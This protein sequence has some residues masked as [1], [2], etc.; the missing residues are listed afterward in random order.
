MTEPSRAFLVALNRN[1]LDATALAGAMPA[2]L[3]SAA[4]V[5]SQDQVDTLLGTKEASIAAGT[6][7][8]VWQGDKTW[9]AKTGLPISTATQTALDLKLDIASQFTVSDIATG[10]SAT[11]PAAAKLCTVQSYAVA[12]YGEGRAVYKR[13]A[14]EPSSHSLKFR[15]TDRFLPDGTTSA[16][17]GGWWEIAES[18]ITPAMAGARGDNTTTDDASLLVWAAACNALGA[19][20]V[21]EPGKIHRCT[22]TCVIALTV[23]Y[24]G[25]GAEFTVPND[26]QSNHLFGFD[27]IAA[28]I[29]VVS[30]ATLNACTGLKKGSNRIPE[31]TDGNWAYWFMSTDDVFMRRGDTPGGSTGQAYGEAFVVTDNLGF[32]AAPLV[33]T[34]ATPFTNLTCYRRKLRQFMKVEGLRIRF[35]AGSSD[36]A[37]RML[38]V[39][40]PRTVFEDC[41]LINESGDNVQQGY[42]CNETAFVYFNR[43]TIF[44]LEEIAQQYGFNFGYSTLCYVDECTGGQCR[45]NLDGTG[46]TYINV[47]KCVFPN[48]VGGHW[49]DNLTVQKSV[50]GHRDIANSHCIHYSGSNVMAIDCHFHLSGGAGGAGYPT[51]ALNM[52]SDLPEI[53]GYAIIRGGSVTIYD[54]DDT[55]SSGAPTV[56]KF[57]GFYS[58]CD[59]GRTLEQPSYIECTPDIII[60]KGAASTNSIYVVALGCPIAAANIPNDI[61]LN[62]RTLI[63]PGKVILEAGDLNGSDPRLIVSAYHSEQSIGDGMDI[64]VYNIEAPYMFVAPFNAASSQ[65][66]GR[67][68]V[69]VE[70]AGPLARYELR[71]GGCKIGRLR[72]CAQVPAAMF[73][74]VASV[75]ALKDEAIDFE[76]F[77]SQHKGLCINPFGGIVQRGSCITVADGAYGPDGWVGLNET[78]DLTSA[79]ATNVADGLPF[80][81]RWTNPDVGAK[82]LGAVSFIGSTESIALRSRLVTMMAN[83]RSTAAITVNYAIL[84]W[85]GTANTPTRDVVNDWADAVLAPGDFFIATT[86][87]VLATGSVALS[88]NTNK[89]TDPL[90]AHVGSSCNNLAMVFWTDTALAQ[91]GYLQLAAD[92]YPGFERPLL[93]RRNVSEER[94][95]CLPWYRSISMTTINGNQYI[96]LSP[97]MVKTPTVTATVGTKANETIDGCNLSH[98]TG[99]ATVVTF[100]G[101][102]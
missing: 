45:R 10:Q 35:I 81:M 67:Y 51:Q 36:T 38:M 29:E 23:P 13:V 95:R 31:L 61:E 55:I 16:G 85:T 3:R 59:Y 47:D 25:N 17:N 6:T 5:Y 39:K 52:R 11:I 66:A 1:L 92:L 15:S 76:D 41:H 49:M 101:D 27:S 77:G 87:N 9:V 58:P 102:I 84:E 2:N 56:M 68:N 82:K 91:N 60:Q 53:S 65:A 43:C 50:L 71:Y 86:T 24:E 4:D 98:T 46:A 8:Q 14:V 40:R 100:A 72:R 21:G 48:G 30:L 78:G 12:N 22:S 93:R 89:I 28:D 26:G 32:L 20:A 70:G 69:L 62:G 44:G 54:E 34:Y 42:V 96:S 79:S 75:A 7:D 37:N 80:M 94:L 88:A 63:R 73:N 83:L 99:A 90:Y 64:E 74:R 18:R 57:D 19:K 33:R 97:P